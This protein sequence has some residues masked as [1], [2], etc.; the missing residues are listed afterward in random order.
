[1]R[2]EATSYRRYRSLSEG[3]ASIGRVLSGWDLGCSPAHCYKSSDAELSQS[4]VQ[5][6]R[7]GCYSVCW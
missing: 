7:P 2:N 5:E 6:R 1:M 3:I 4:R